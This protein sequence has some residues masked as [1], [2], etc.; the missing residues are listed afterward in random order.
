MKNIAIIGAGISGLTIAQLLK[1]KYHPT[2]FENQRVAGGLVK[3]KRV[4]GH[5]YHMVGGHVFNSKR[6]D[7]LNLFWSFFERDIEFTKAN[8]NAAIYLDKPIGYPIENHL[9]ELD[10]DLIKKIISELLFIN[11]HGE[12]N[13]E[14]FEDFLTGRFGKTLY[15]IYFKPYNEKIWKCDLSNVS[16]SWLAGKLPMPT[17]E[18]ILYSNIKNESEN[19]MVH[20]SFYYP[21]Y[22]GSQFLIDRLSQGLEILCDAKIS[23]IS[24]NEINKKWIINNQSE[25]DCLIYAGN[26]KNLPDIVDI[27]VGLNPFKERI[28]KLQYHG[29]TTVLCEIDNNPYSWVYLP[30][31]SI[32]AHRIINTGNFSDSNNNHGIKTATIEFTDYVDEK[33]IKENLS[34]M[35]FSPKYITHEY[36]KYTYPIQES[37]TREL[38]SDIKKT[39]EPKGMYI[40][41]RFAE[42]EYYNMDAAM[43]AAIDLS[44]KL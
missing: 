19:N 5:L 11:K 7:V 3:C 30:D 26:L 2:L 10:P 21:N 14:N 12:T 6:Q 40:L 23:S 28:E 24:R 17:I 18:E 15:S 35:P 44:K 8:R 13:H 37:N 20:S 9:N 16:L 36:T 38:I 43:G 39:I 29:T 34:R 31:P 33:I 1:H 22:N 41:G 4:D 42:W 25:F 27:N 32:A